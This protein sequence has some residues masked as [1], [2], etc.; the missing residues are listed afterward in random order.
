MHQ[1]YRYV[2]DKN[3]L[4]FTIQKHILYRKKKKCM[5][6]K[7]LTC[8]FFGILE[9]NNNNIDIFLLK[10]FWIYNNIYVLNWIK[11]FLVY[12]CMYEYENVDTEIVKFIF[13][14]SSI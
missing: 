11:R 5:I 8:K 14:E 6:I 10:I 9:L 4:H 13:K 2:Y 7:V 1:I 3:K 12:F